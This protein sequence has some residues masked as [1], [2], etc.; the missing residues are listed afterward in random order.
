MNPSNQDILTGPKGGRIRGSSL[1]IM[2]IIITIPASKIIRWRGCGLP[3]GPRQARGSHI[4]TCIQVATVSEV[5]AI[6]QIL[7][8]KLIAS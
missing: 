8:P 1:Y 7:A 6:L 5:L 4:L 3:T 2:I